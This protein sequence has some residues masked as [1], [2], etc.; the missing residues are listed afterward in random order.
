[1]QVAPVWRCFG[2]FTRHPTSVDAAVGIH[3][4]IDGGETFEHAHENQSPH[5]DVITVRRMM[6]RARESSMDRLNIQFSYNV[7]SFQVWS[8]CKLELSG[9]Q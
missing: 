5:R 8:H 9:G 3:E 1:M 6:I 7:L 2:R 4:D